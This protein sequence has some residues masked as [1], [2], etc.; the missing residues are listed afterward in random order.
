MSLSAQN[1]YNCKFESVGLLLLDKTEIYETVRFYEYISRINVVKI[2]KNV[3]DLRAVM[4][5]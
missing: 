1:R 3:D 2:Q 4:Y 5:F